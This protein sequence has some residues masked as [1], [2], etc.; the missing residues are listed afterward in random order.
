MNDT[1]QQ[2]APIVKPIP[3]TDLMNTESSLKKK[4]Q[5]SVCREQRTISSPQLLSDT[6]FVFSKGS[7]SLVKPLYSTAMN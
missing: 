3:L 6:G 4:A 1:A 5:H 2:S 7:L